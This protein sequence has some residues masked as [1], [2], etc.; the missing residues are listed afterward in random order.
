MVLE[1]INQDELE[2]K[3]D[4]GYGDI[5]TPMQLSIIEKSIRGIC[6]ATR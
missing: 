5:T 6:G 1:L 2:M 3:G 4:K